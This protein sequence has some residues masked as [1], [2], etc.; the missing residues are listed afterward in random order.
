MAGGQRLEGLTPKILRD[1]IVEGNFILA[2]NE[3]LQQWNTVG[4]ANV[5]LDLSA[6]RSLADRL[7][8]LFELGEYL[9]VG[10]AGILGAKALQVAKGVFIDETDQPI[11]LQERILQRC[12]GHQNLGV[13]LQGLFEFA[14]YLAIG[15]IDVAE[16]MGLIHHNQVPGHARQIWGLVAGE[17][18]GTDNGLAGSLKWVVTAVALFAIE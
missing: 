14:G 13:T 17:L 5:L 9:L 11:E 7:E 4:V 8:S 15:S 1:Q 16:S 10:E 3:L 6:Q 2:G 12:G 18:I